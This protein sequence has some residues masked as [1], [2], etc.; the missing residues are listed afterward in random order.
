M[1]LG[2][3]QRLIGINNLRMD[4]ATTCLVTDT[5]GRRL[6]NDAVPERSVRV[7]A[8]AKAHSG[9]ANPVPDLPNGAGSGSRLELA[10]VV[11][12]F[13][14]FVSFLQLCRETDSLLGNWCADL[15]VIAVDDGSLESVGP[16][17]FDPPLVNIKR[18]RLVKLACN[19]GHQRAIAIGL[20]EAVTEGGFD[21]VLVA[22]SDGEDRPV[23]IGR[24]IA[25][26]RARG[27]VIVVAR[28]SKRSEGLRFR[29]FYSIYKTMFHAFTGKKIDF[30]NFVLLPNAPLARL[31]HMTETWN[32]LAASIL[33]SR[34]PLSAVACQRGRRY[35]GSSSMNLVSLLVHGLS[36]VSV[37]SDFVL[38]R[39]LVASSAITVIAAVMGVTAVVI[40]LTTTLA[41][42]GWAT[43]MVGISVI[44]LLQALLFSMVASLTMLRHRSAV[45]FV[46]SVHAQ[47][48]VGERLTLFE[49]SQMSPIR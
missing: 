37:F 25:E 49:A 34:L 18:V 6:V 4:H 16:V 24:L 9:G 32:H 2:S 35:A 46:P 21:A 39:M 19:L 44:I 10:L 28:R 3:R 17:L 40:R 14:D 27:D 20:V 42:P 47:V 48:F 11:P 7:Q 45:A 29:V 38:A 8:M 22:D 13:N 31:V 23:D 43:S 41:V 30:G 36:A 12:V 26:H 15:S 1:H 5:T 33:R